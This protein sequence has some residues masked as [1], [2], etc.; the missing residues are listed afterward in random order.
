MKIK[1][2]SNTG[3]ARLM[4]TTTGTAMPADCHALVGYLK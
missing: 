2:T 3:T 4:Q 1:A